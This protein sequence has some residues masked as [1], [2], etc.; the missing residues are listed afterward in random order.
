[1]TK[2]RLYLSLP[3]MSG[4]ERGF[5]QE[6]LAS[7]WIASLGPQVDAFA[8]EF[9][10]AVGVPYALVSGSTAILADRLQ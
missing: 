9:A 4:L 7:N 2:Q 8:A 5:V 3:H 1:M 10:A 6:T